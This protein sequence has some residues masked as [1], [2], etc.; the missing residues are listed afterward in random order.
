MCSD[1]V[2]SFSNHGLCTTRNR[3]ELNEIFRQ[4]NHLSMF[5][6]I[7][8]PQNH[9][10]KV[11]G[12]EQDRSLHHF[13]FVM[14]RGTYKDFKRGIK[15]NRSET[16]N[17]KISLHSSH[18]VADI[19]GWI[20]E[21]FSAPTGFITEIK[22]K[23]S[24][25]ISEAPV[26]DIDVKKRQCRFWDESHKLTSFRWYSRINCLLE[27]KADHAEKI[28]GCRPWDYPHKNENITHQTK[29]ICD[30][31][32]NSCFNMVLENNRAATCE[33]KCDRDCNEISYSVSVINYPIDSDSNICDFNKDPNTIMEHKI[34]KHMLSLYSRVSIQENK[35]YQSN[36]SPEQ[37][38]MNLIQDVMS[39][40]NE[41]VTTSNEEAFKQDCKAKLNSDIAV[42][43]VGIISPKYSRMAKVVKATWFDKL[44]VFGKKINKISY[45][46]NYHITVNIFPPILMTIH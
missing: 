32:G 3:A 37:R 12:I 11:V 16:S 30:F 7:F 33:D 18:D 45:V 40:T 19:R 13:T 20:N 41:S 39:G 36:Y 46:G 26:R 44:A 14:D 8:K 29:K 9:E 27:C 43:D 15:W 42:I 5:Q 34:K 10:T 38:L 31:Y 4:S 24:Q 35:N 21:V 1:F 2:P 17:F 28:C 25:L 22:I 23:L 6:K